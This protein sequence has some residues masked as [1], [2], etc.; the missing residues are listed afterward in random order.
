[1]D[2]VTGGP[3]DVEDD[4]QH[5]GCDDGTQTSPVSHHRHAGAARRRHSH[6]ARDR[7]EHVR[8]ERRERAHGD[9]VTVHDAHPVAGPV[10]AGEDGV[11]VQGHD[12]H[13]ENEAGDRHVEEEHIG[14][15]HAAP[16]PVQ[17]GD[18]ERVGSDREQH[19]AH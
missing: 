11:S 3:G 16:A 2:D 14:R 6:A 8:D 10:G 15:G 12:A 17:H 5:P 18:H 19:G 13:G 9:H 4:G 7:D 1:M